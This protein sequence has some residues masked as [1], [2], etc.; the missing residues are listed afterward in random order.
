MNIPKTL[1]MILKANNIEPKD[2]VWQTHK[3]H[4]LYHKTAERLADVYGI[5]FDEPTILEQNEGTIAIMVKGRRGLNIDALKTLNEEEDRYE[6]PAVPKEVWKIGEVNPQNC[7]IAYPWAMAEKRAKDRVI[8]ALL[9]IS[10]DVY[11]DAE[12]EE[13]SHAK[14]EN[15]KQAQILMHHNAV[16]REYIEEIAITKK[17]LAKPVEQIDWSKIWETYEAEIPEKSQIALWVATTKGGVWT[18]RERQLIKQEPLYHTWKKEN[19]SAKDWQ[20]SKKEGENNE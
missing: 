8:L 15:Y 20:D 7:K 14:D 19:L 4:V 10:G 9:G 1:E 16:V 13:W 12:A 2:A 17:E 6:Y 5:T 3:N 18:T 11:S